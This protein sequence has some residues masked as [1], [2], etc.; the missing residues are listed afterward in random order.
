MPGVPI[1][2]GRA[3]CP[4]PVVATYE[5][6]HGAV[7]R[8]WTAPAVGPKPDGAPFPAPC[9]DDGTM[10]GAKKVDCAKCHWTKAF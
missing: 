10:C 8:T 7:P 3:G 4:G 1:Q 9:P 6:P 2:C 5:H